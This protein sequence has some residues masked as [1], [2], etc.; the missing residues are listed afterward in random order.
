MATTQ[1][2]S[3]LTTTRTEETGKTEETPQK[4]EPKEKE[5]R[6]IIIP[7][8]P[9]EL[10]M[11]CLAGVSLSHYGTLKQVNKVWY[12]ALTSDF[13]FKLRKTLDKTEDLL[14]LFRNDPSLT[15]GELFNP[16]RG[17]WAMIPPMPCDTQRYGL[18][19]FACVGVAGHIYVL[20]GS[21]FDARSF[22]LGRPVASGRVF[23]YD[24]VRQ[25][26]ER[27]SP[28]RD[29][30]GSFACAVSSDG[31]S[32]LVAGG[33]SRH[34]RHGGMASG[35]RIRSVEVYDVA[36][37]RW[38][39]EAELFSERAGCAGFF[40]G[41]EFWVMG[42]YGNSITVG[43]VVLLDEHFRDGAVLD[44]SSRWRRL[45]PMWSQGERSRLGKIA[46]L[47]GS[48]CARASIY[49]LQ[50]FDLYRYNME[51]NKWEKESSLPQKVIAEEP[52]GLVALYD[53]LY[54]I[55]GCTH[56][57]YNFP[58]QRR[59]ERITLSFQVYNPKKQTWRF[60]LTKPPIKSP[61]SFP[62]AAMCSLTL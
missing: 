55:P 18:T 49:M 62:W 47:H 58:R 5:E 8:L 7:G 17:A 45:E 15:F 43:G 31:S 2:I 38:R 52:C 50:D 48:D 37:N 56:T 30:R 44:S 21:V 59:R 6:S 32:I 12:A 9:N 57:D 36:R 1:K 61:L 28:M 26:W 53:E 3:S 23:R 14:C 39:F 54:V 10:A 22:P 41:D 25:K 40:L 60:I 16:K 19:N 51:L 13:L 27:R 35:S 46:V 24:P 29:P 33:G 20:G 4:Q 42:G 11:I 34:A